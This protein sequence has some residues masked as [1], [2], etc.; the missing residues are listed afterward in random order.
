MQLPDG[1]LDDLS[2][3]LAPYSLEFESVTSSPDG[4]IEVCF[5]AD[6]V[7]FANAHP[8]L[9]VEQSYGRSWPPSA[10]HLLLRFG[11]HLDPMAAEFENLDL[12][13]GTASVDRG[14]RDRLNTL[15][16]PADHAVAVGEAMGRALAD[17]APGS[18]DYLE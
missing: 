17:T 14:L 12:L 15:A 7:S 5:S 8:D 2:D 16:D 4:E 13:A 9:G 6:P 10:L 11:R 3:E 18:D 1:Y